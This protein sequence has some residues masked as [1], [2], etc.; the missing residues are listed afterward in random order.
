MWLLKFI[1]QKNLI[2]E[3]FISRGD[4][5]TG[6][7]IEL[8][9]KKGVKLDDYRDNF[10]LWTEAMNELGIIPEEYLGER[11]LE[12]ELPW[13]IVDVGVSKEFFKRELK[14]SEKKLLFHMT[15]EKGVWAAE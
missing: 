14:K 12:A 3:G 10:N 11:D 2:L 8:A 15:A 1:R 4:E 7:L 9:F 13:D 5:R 6:D